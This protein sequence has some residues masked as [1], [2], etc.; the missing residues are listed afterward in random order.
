MN[1]L[2]RFN[3]RTYQVAD[4]IETLMDLLTDNFASLFRFITKSGSK[5]HGSFTNFINAY[6]TVLSLF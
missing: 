3:S 1:K 6:T 2:L 5:F 4:A